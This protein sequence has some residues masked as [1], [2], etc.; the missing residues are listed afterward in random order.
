[1]SPLFPPLLAPG[2]D[3][4]GDSVTHF[5]RDLLEYLSAYRHHRLTAWID[6]ARRHDFSTAKW[7]FLCSVHVCDFF[8]V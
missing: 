8:D 5:K 4:I 3:S 7:D 1:V 6:I 2:G